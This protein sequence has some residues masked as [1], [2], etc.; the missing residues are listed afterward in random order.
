MPEIEP[1][2]ILRVDSEETAIAAIKAAFDSVYE[3]ESVRLDF[4]DWPLL[5]LKYTGD[6]FDGTIT[7]DI[8]QA[9]VDLQEVLNRT[10]ALAVNHTS[11][12]RSLSDDDR[13][14]LQVTA[15]V[16]EGSSLIEVNLGDWATKLSLDLAGKMAGTDIVV[17]ILGCA[18]I[19]TAGWIYKYHLKN[20]S[21]EKKLTL[22]ND[23]R[24]NLSQEETERLRIVT[25]AMKGNSVVREVASF[26][27]GLRDS[28]LKSAFDAESFTVQGDLTITGEEAR[29][30][31]RSKRREPIEVQLNGTY[32]IRSFTWAEDQQSARVKVQ[33]E[34]KNSEFIADL[35]VSA[36]NTEQ[37]SRFKDA[38]FDQARVYL[39]INATVLNDQVTTAT[40]ISVDEQPQSPQMQPSS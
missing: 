20:R 2:E 11:S 12:L 33:R 21:E 30:T 3:G 7:P 14:D 16:E 35:S 31:Y 40:I 38:T 10:Y 13:R 4:D 24:F 36:L 9:I 22:E 39:Q 15:T 5:K 8:A 34:D 37:R 23:G 18:V 29:R 32:F 17:T 26:S 28:F 25:E 19:V 1:H 6:K 27:E